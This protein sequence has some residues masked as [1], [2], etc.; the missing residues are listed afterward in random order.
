VA[1]KLHIDGGGAAGET[2]ASLMPSEE[3]DAYWIFATRKVGKYPRHTERGGKWLVFVPPDAV[4]EVWSRIKRTTEE[5]RLGGASKVATARPNP[6]ARSKAK[7]IC[8]YT[9]D[10]KDEDDVRRVREELRKLGIVDKIFYKTDE[11]TRRGRYGGA[12]E[13]PVSKYTS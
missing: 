13:G 9:Y 12:G 5:G 11:D 1:Q 6:H 4:D 2:A 8:V 7:V 3:K 10:W